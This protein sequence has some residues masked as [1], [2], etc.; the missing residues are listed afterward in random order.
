MNRYAKACIFVV[1]NIAMIYFIFT[2]ISSYKQDFNV[3]ARELSTG[4]E[5]VNNNQLNTSNT[6]EKKEPSESYIESMKN[7][8]LNKFRPKINISQ[9][10][11]INVE[12]T[13][14]DTALAEALTDSSEIDLSPPNPVIAAEIKNIS[15]LVRSYKII[16]ILYCCCFI[17]GTVQRRNDNKEKVTKKQ[18]FVKEVQTGL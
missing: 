18:M 6:Q 15:N 4:D 8:L 11:N 2:N 13:T 12:E 10:N 3:N 9:S 1:I 17:S 16:E 14:V 7:L 5:R